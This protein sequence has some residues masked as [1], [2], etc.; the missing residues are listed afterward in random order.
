[1]SLLRGTLNFKYEHA[2]LL[3]NAGYRDAKHVFEQWKKYESIAQKEQNVVHDRKLLILQ[4]KRYQEMIE[5][6]RKNLHLPDEVE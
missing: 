1:M 3:I 2:M 6:H 4:Q 5:K